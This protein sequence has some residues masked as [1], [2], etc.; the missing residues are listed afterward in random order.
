M[1][2]S[3]IGVAGIRVVSYVFYALEFGDFFHQCFLYALFQGEIYC[4]ATLS[5]ATKL[6]YRKAIGYLG[7]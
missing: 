6:Q 7:Q 5:A 3:H 1:G 4:R 2:L